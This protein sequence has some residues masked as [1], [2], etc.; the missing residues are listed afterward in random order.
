MTSFNWSWLRSIGGKLNWWQTPLGISIA[1]WEIKI[2]CQT[3]LIFPGQYGFT[4][5]MIQLVV[6]RNNQG[7]TYQVMVNMELINTFD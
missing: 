4:Q 5:D 3:W 6:D 2:L 1:A 7:Q